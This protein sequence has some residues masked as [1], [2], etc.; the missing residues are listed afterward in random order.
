MADAEYADFSN[1]PSS[2]LDNCNGSP[3]GTDLGI[4]VD[5]PGTGASSKQPDWG[6]YWS[7]HTYK[8]DYVGLGTPPVFNYHDCNLGDNSGSLT[9]AVYKVVDLVVEGPI[10]GT[11]GMI[12]QLVV[13]SA[14]PGEKIGVIAGTIAGSTPVPDCPGL[15]VSI[16]LPSLIGTETADADGIARID[17]DFPSAFSGKTVLFQAVEK[18]TCEVSNVRTWMFP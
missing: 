17:R 13:S 2:L 9:V 18:G 14:T 16:L 6:P 7:F 15:S 1:P 3:S 5:D 4:G 12:N 11:A 8:V 10:P